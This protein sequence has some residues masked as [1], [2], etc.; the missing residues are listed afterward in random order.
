LPELLQQLL[1]DLFGLKLLGDHNQV[2]DR[3]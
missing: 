3:Q 2:F 1:L